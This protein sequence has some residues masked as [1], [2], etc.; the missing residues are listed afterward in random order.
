MKARRAAWA[1]AA[2]AFVSRVAGAGA[3]LSYVHTFGDSAD[4]VTTLGWGLAIISVIVFAAVFLLLAGGVL[5]R[6]PPAAPGALAVRTDAGGLPW[7][8]IGVGITV[9]VL[10]G[11]AV[12]TMLTLRATAMPAGAGQLTL[13]VSGAQWWWRVHYRDDAAARGFETANE[14]H[15]PVGRPVRVELASEDVI[16]SF[17]IPQLAGKIDMIP[18][19]TNV[20]WLHAARRGTYRGQCGEFCGAQHAHM[21]MQ[22]VADEPADFARWRDNQL[23]AAPAPAPATAQAGGAREFVAHCGACH[24]VRGTPAGGIVGPDLTHLMSRNTIAAGA[25]SNTTGNL[26]AWIADPGAI[27]PGTRMP[28]QT[29]S[30]AELQAIVGFLQTLH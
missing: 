9:V 28:A 21:A 22:V 15:I 14:I 24:T 7:I 1:F 29:V 12:W 20:L 6:R 8:Y 23:R 19:Q 16:H 26:A 4:P 17:W 11:C 25:L 2:G 3:P 5:R 10:A 30:P 27:K 18:G 13:R